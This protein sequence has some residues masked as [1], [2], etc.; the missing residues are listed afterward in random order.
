MQVEKVNSDLKENDEE[1]EIY[2]SLG[3][4]LEAQNKKTRYELLMLNLKVKE[5]T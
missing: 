3:E 5:L 2:C 4:W 1:A